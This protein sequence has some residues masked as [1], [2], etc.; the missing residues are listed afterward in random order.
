MV[1]ELVI[2]STAVIYTVFALFLQRK[3]SN[4]IRARE[5]QRRLKEHTKALSE[6][7]KRGADKSA[8]MAKQREVM[9]L[10]SE[11]MKNQMRSIFAVIPTFL[12]F[13]YAI[14][15]YIIAAM[16]A[17]SM[18]V[19]F[20]FSGLSYESLFFILV[21]I[22]GIFSS[23]GIMVYDRKKSKDEALAA[24]KGNA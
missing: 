23:I 19:T 1:V 8:I 13:Y 18:T 7:A 21:F 12:V 14:V 2:A 3:L 11:T 16:G 17:S 6:M 15:P 24:E 22:F 20:I 5:I 4:P 9:P 10:M